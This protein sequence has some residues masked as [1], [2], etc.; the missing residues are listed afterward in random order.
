MHL[1]GQL[2]RLP[3]VFC[4]GQPSTISWLVYSCVT[5]SGKDGTLEPGVEHIGMEVLIRIPVLAPACPTFRTGSRPRLVYSGSS[6][7]VRGVAL[8]GDLHMPAS[9]GP[10]VEFFD[11]ANVYHGTLT[12][13]TQERCTAVPVL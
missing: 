6:H 12:A 4:A 2:I 1:S 9:A 8:S 3:D 11:S 13:I 7:S 10:C 5:V